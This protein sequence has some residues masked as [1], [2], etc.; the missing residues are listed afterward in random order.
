MNTRDRLFPTEVRGDD[1]GKKWQ[2]MKHRIPFAELNGALTSL[3][4]ENLK[5]EFLAVCAGVATGREQ[6]IL[7]PSSQLVAAARLTV[8][9]RG[10]VLILAYR[11]SDDQP[12]HARVYKLGSITRREGQQVVAEVA[13]RVPKFATALSA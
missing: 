7:S 6:Q 2:V 8:P 1:L 5:S 11:V 13:R 12:V 9:T 4:P 10:F 3:D